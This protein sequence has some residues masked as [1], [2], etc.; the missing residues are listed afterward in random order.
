MWRFSCAGGRDGPKMDGGDGCPIE[1]YL[2]PPNCTLK[3][4]KAVNATLHI[5][6]HT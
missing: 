3:I 5:F 1:M 2:M 6:Y 4:A